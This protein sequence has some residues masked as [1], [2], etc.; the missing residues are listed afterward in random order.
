[1]DAAVPIHFDNNNLLDALRTFVGK[2]DAKLPTAETVLGETES[3]P[4]HKMS[5]L[6][7]S[8]LSD[9]IIDVVDDVPPAFDCT[10][11]EVETRTVGL[12][13]GENSL[14]K[15]IVCDDE[16]SSKPVLVLNDGKAF[17]RS[18][19]VGIDSM[20]EADYLTL[21]VREEIITCKRARLL[22]KTCWQKNCQGADTPPDRL[23]DR[24]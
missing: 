2:T 13:P 7:S 15:S 11:A 10:V 16:S 23:H 14:M 24:Q 6:F 18:G 20:L 9:G 17:A 1:M 12:G 19:A 4:K 8:I 22:L 21:L 3:S 5:G